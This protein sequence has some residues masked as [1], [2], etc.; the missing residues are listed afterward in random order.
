MQELW[1]MIGT[2]QVIVHLPL[3]YVNFPANAVNFYGFILDVAKFQMFNVESFMQ[4][5]FYFDESFPY[6]DQFDA[7]DIF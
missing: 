6:N 3:I 7:I 2:M 1:G 4:F 5:L